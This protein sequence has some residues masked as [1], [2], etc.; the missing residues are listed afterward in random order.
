MDNKDK[1]EKPTLEEVE[2]FKR[3]LMVPWDHCANVRQHAKKLC[4]R[5]VED[6]EF[7]L[8]LKIA[9]RIQSHDVSKFSGIEFEYLT[10]NGASKE[11]VEMA[12]KEHQSNNDHHPEFFTDGIKSMCMEQIGELVVDWASRSSEQ[13]TD[14]RMWIKETATKKYNFTLHSNVYKKIK[15]FVDLLLD[16]PFKKLH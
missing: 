9:Q 4:M 6:G 16:P 1:P 13:G 7:N 2:D 12:V 3:R 5:L 11:Q 14:L 8:A 10:N 15:Y